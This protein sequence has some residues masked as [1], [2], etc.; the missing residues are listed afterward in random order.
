MAENKNKLIEQYVQ[1]KLKKSE[2]WTT[3][4]KERAELINKVIDAK[5]KFK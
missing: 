5:R 4:K 1:S 2:R 3:F